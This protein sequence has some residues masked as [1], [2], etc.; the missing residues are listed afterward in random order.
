MR[1]LVPV[2]PAIS[3][4]YVKGYKWAE[5]ISGCDWVVGGA[6]DDDDG[7]NLIDVVIC[8]WHLICHLGGESEGK[9]KESETL[10]D[11]QASHIVFPASNGPEICD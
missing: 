11:L 10:R 1:L 3:T 5:T 4:G 2:L 8:H 6:E 7:A 9:A